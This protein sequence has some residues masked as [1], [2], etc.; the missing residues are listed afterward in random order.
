MSEDRSR[1]PSSPSY[2]HHEHSRDRSRSPRPPREDSYS[3]SLRVASLETL[4]GKTEGSGAG[5]S[6]LGR[7]HWEN[8]HENPQDWSNSRSAAAALTADQHNA[9]AA[10]WREA[11]E[12]GEPRSSSPAS[13]APLPLPGLLASLAA[14]GGK[15]GSGSPD[16]S[17]LLAG[18][19]LSQLPKPAD[20]IQQAQALQLLAHLQTVLINSGQQPPQLGSSGGL[21]QQQQSISQLMHSQAQLQKVKYQTQ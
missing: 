15:N 13:N 5:H 11:R 12:T 4:T 2:T 16:L 17:Q 18:G 9:A 19:Q 1:S 8:K 6:S 20:L 14:G 7:R 3:A 10:A 21:S